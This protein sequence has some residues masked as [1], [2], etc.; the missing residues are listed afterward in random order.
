[1]TEI[2]DISHKDIHTKHPNQIIQQEV[3]SDTETDINENNDNIINPL[4]APSL[5]NLLDKDDSVNNTQ[6]PSYEVMFEDLNHIETEFAQFRQT[7]YQ[8][9]LKKLQYELFMILDGSHPS[10]NNYIQSVQKIKDSKFKKINNNLK[11]KL[12]CINKET[13]ATRTMIHQ[14]HMKKY[15]DL[16]ERMINDTTNDWYDINNEKRYLDMIEQE[17]SNKEEYIAKF[18]YEF[19]K[20]NFVANTNI[21]NANS[22]NN[23][24]NNKNLSILMQPNKYHL[25]L[26]IE[27]KSLSMI[28]NYATKGVEFLPS[29]NKASYRN[30]LTED[31]LLEN[32]NFH[33]AND[34][35]DKLE[36]IVDRM[37][38]NNMMSDFVGLRKFYGGF[39]SVPELPKIKELEILQDFNKIHKDLTWNLQKYP[40]NMQRSATSN[41]SSYD[42]D[43]LE[44][45]NV[46]NYQE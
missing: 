4:N 3:Q 19:A 20:R 38:F 7:V 43:D 29:N 13:K 24:N 27:N 31:M 1:M 33:F 25:P 35:V 11:T 14:N 41:K 28:T 17:I 39:P 9:K 15:M 6:R 37:R 10:L 5:Q 26:K 42:N 34:P 18:G 23:N 40:E 36:V 8:I 16:K 2:S 22:T 21:M 44:N 30:A 12:N 46:S 45:N 32:I